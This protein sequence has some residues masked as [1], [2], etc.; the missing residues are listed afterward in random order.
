[1][2]LDDGLWDNAIIRK[3][4]AEHKIVPQ[5]DIRRLLERPS[6]ASANGP[7]ALG[8]VSAHRPGAADVH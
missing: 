4:L 5:A 2:A 6:N 3:S 1:M 7:E 8:P